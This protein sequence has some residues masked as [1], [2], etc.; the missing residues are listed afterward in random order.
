MRKSHLLLPFLLLVLFISQTGIT[1]VISYPDSWDKQG[2]TLQKQIKGGVEVN[3]SIT[4]FSFEDLDIDGE[5]FKTIKVPGIF[6]PNDEGA[7]DLPGTGKYIVIPQ[8]SK[9]SLKVIATRT[10]TIPD[11]EIAP[12]PRIPF[13]TEYGPLHYEKDIKIYSKDEYYPKEPVIISEK[14]NIRGVDV[15]MLGVTPFQYNPVSKELIVYRDIQVEITYTDGNG[16]FGENRLRSR[17]WDP[18]IKDA[19]LN[20]HA[21]PY[22]DYSKKQ[23]GSKTPDYEYIIITPDDPTFLSWADSIKTFRTL[24]GIKTGV[25]TTTEIGGNTTTAIET[26]VNDAYNNWDIPPVAVLLLAIMDQVEIQ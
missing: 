9:A 4:E 6:L 8:G 5:Q 11:V 21:I 25:V 22:I 2:I 18:L 16:Y 23:S 13:D 20:P 24:Q 12:A 14:T 1:Q 7:P 15:V 10:E 26:Y 17:W 19:V 3:Y